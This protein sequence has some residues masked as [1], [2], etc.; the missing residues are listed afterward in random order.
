MGRSNIGDCWIVIPGGGMPALNVRRGVPDARSLPLAGG[1]AL[2][3]G[4]L[5]HVHAQDAYL[6]ASFG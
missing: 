5:A 6:H 4:G 3:L 2:G 1:A